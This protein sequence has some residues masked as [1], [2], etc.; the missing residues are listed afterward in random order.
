MSHFWK[1][2][3]LIR[4]ITTHKNL[5]KGTIPQKGTLDLLF[6]KLMPFKRGL[7][8]QN[9]H[10][11]KYVKYYNQSEFEKGEKKESQNQLP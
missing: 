6:L 9:T 1:C 11:Q 2:E 3:M 4:S 8:E 5:M 10:I 7:N